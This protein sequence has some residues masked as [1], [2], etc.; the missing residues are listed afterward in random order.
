MER[1][2]SF[3]KWFVAILILGSALFLYLA[4]TVNYST[5]QRAGRV[6]KFSKKGVVFKTYEGQLH[7]GGFADDGDINASQ[8]SFS[9]RS[10][11]DK[12]MKDLQSAMD[13]G[14]RVKLYYEQKYLTLPFIGET[15]YYI[16]QVQKVEEQ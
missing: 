7:L 3:L 1:I 15:T 11:D 13:K 12:V 10:K 14:Y 6:I 4:L 2:K 9:V 8:F 5:G 16:T